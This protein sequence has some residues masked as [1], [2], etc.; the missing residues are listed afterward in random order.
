MREIKVNKYINIQTG[1]ELDVYRVSEL[2]DNAMLKVKP[3]LFNEW[4]FE[5]NIKLG[6]N[7]YNMT[8]G[9][10]K[11]AWWICPKCKS[12]YDSA[13]N[14]RTMRNAKCSYCA[15][16]RVNSSNSLE[17]LRPD[18]AKQWHHTKNGDLTPDKVPCGTGK[19]VW[20][21]CEECKGSYPQRIDSKIRGSGCSICTGKYVTEVNCL[22]NTNQEVCSLLLNKE[23]GYKYTQY[24]DKRL[25]WKCPD[26]DNIIR[27]KQIK[28]VSIDGLSCGECSDGVS[29]PEKVVSN[30]LRLLNVNY[31]NDI[32][33]EFSDKKRYDF[34][35]NHNNESFIIEV[36]GSQHYYDGFKAF[37]SRS[38]NFEREND[39]IKEALAMSNGIDNYIVID[40]RKSEIGFIKESIIKSKLSE[41]FNLKELEWDYINEKSCKSNKVELL[42][43]YLNGRRDF[44]IMAKDLNVDY[45]TVMV[46]IKYWSKTGKIEYSPLDTRKKV[47]Q[48][49]MN[50]EFVK[51]WDSVADV[52]KYFK[53]V[54]KVLKNER[55][56]DKGSRFIY[57]D[58]YDLYLQDNNSYEFYENKDITKK[59]VQLTK[60][61][62]FIREWD[63]M[64]EASRSL[65]KANQSGIAG[66]CKGHKNT[67]AGYRWMYL[68]EYHKLT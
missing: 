54:N 19:K 51:E 4:D 16:Q 64:I 55:S 28:T 21:Y 14:E 30:M 56:N 10:S 35:F 41:V 58:D 27:N 23:N 5:K 9:M 42:N 44:K 49:T 40:A 68:N 13:I 39:K 37:S 61:G 33:T 3:E 15:G 24:S 65:G 63:S 36:H 11:K 60:D 18:I 52:R 46:W 2:K 48:L 29:F 62:N 43:M 45:A 50:L 25:D 32:S 17:S 12:D 66:V 22:A 1:E 20:W 57:K 67:S 6:L 53:N 34:V 38:S 8:K 59:I 31:D 7:I 47:V 26:C